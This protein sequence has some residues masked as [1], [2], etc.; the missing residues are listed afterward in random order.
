MEE[1]TKV[2]IIEFFNR[3]EKHVYRTSDLANILSE[4]RASWKGLRSWSQRK[5][6]NLLLESTDLRK[7]ALRSEKYGD[8]SRYVWRAASE[9][10]IALSLRRNSYLTHATA[11]FLHG[12]NDQIPGT[13]YVNHEQS[14]KPGGGVLTQ[15]GINR[16]FKSPQRQ[17]NYVF[18]HGRRKIL[19]VNGKNTGRL[20]VIHLLGP[21][22]ERLEVTNIERTLIDSSVRP[23]YAGGIFQVV[24]AF[25]RARKV[26]S[27]DQLISTLKQLD[28][29]Y[30]YH[31]LI[32]FYMEKAGYD[33]ASLTKME[34]FGIA[35]DF[36]ATYG[37]KKTEYNERW[38]LFYPRGM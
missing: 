34:A 21:T 29:L 9:Y 4:N 31:Q 15:E 2:K 35:F 3:S 24:E 6:I 18:D 27:V 20:G 17:S 36:Y 7:V 10:E 5:F 16:A 38:R 1:A 37:L 28:Y 26:V 30:P 25:K 33:E 22:K 14:V 13:I 19:I 23:A 11:I 12:L 8:E 32:G